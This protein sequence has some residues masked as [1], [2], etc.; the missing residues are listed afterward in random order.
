[1]STTDSDITHTVLTL[2]PHVP[3]EE[4]APKAAQRVHCQVL[5]NPCPAGRCCPPCT[6]LLVTQRNLG[7]DLGVLNPARTQWAEGEA[8]L[9]GGAG[10]Q[11]PK[12]LRLYPPPQGT[13]E[14]ISSRRIIS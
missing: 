11:S 13:A 1:M 9:K 8:E 3:T 5:T 10:L 6:S 14:Q 2:T 7:L 12:A 4:M